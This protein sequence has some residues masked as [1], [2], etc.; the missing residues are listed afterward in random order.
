MAKTGQRPS[1]DARPLGLDHFGDNTK[2]RTAGLRNPE[3]LGIWDSNSLI[4]R[5]V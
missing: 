2:R 4:K 3:G 5:D 1:A